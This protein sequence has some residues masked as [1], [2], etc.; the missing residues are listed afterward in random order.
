MKD[1]GHVEPDEILR[2]FSK[3]LA[4]TVQGSVFAVLQNDIQRICRLNE[5]M[6][7]D[8]IRMLTPSLVRVVLKV[9]VEG[10][11]V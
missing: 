8:N 6:I 11:Y 9:E 2:E 4:D 3:I 1:L 10:P 5:A 7:L